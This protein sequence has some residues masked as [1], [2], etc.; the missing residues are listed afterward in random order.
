LNETLS[1]L[2]TFA[3]LEL[4]DLTTSSTYFMSI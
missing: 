4:I 1:L 2:I 3:G